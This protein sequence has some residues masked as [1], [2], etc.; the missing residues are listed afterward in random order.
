MIM[1]KTKTKSKPKKKA[2]KRKVVA[3]IKKGP[4]PIGVVKHFFGKIKVAIIRFA[5]TVPV[6]ATIEVRGATT[7][8]RFTIDSMQFDHKPVKHA[9][10]KKLIGIKVPKRVREGDNVFLS[11]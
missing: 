9:K 11:K 6:G 3:A 2:I 7:N 10:P 1:K 4:K 8:F 5:K